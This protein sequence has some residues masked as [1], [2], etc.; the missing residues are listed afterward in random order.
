MVVLAWSS[1]A[2]RRLRRAAPDLVGAPAPRSPHHEERQWGP[3]GD[4]VVQ[5]AALD[6]AAAALVQAAGATTAPQ[7]AVASAAAL[8]DA[9][10]GAPAPP[11]LRLA[12]RAPAPDARHLAAAALLDGLLAGP[13]TAAA[14][15]SVPAPAAPVPRWVQS[16]AALLEGPGEFS[17]QSAQI[18]ATADRMAA[19]ALHGPSTE[20]AP[21]PAPTPELAAAPELAATPDPAPNPEPAPELAA[22]AIAEEP[23]EALPA[24][25]RRR[26]SLWSVIAWTPAV[27]AVLVAGALGVWVLRGG[28]VLVMSTPSMGTTAQVGSLVLTHPLGTE[29]IHR[30]MLVAF[31]APGTGAI[32]MHRVAAVLPGGRIRTRGDLNS[33]DDGWYLTRDAI[34][35]TPTLIVPWLGWIVLGAPWAFGALLLGWLLTL[36][37]PRAWRPALRYCALGLGVALAIYRLHPLVRVTIITSGKIGH[38]VAAGLV[39][40]GVLPVRVTLRAASVVI[41][42]GHL[43]TIAASLGNRGASVISAHPDVP[44]WGWIALGAVVLMPL[45]IGLASLRHERRGRPLIA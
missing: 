18:G 42:P 36:A 39:N 4:A 10:A 27:I 28:S 20:P 23:T 7:A 6:A 26:I 17:A 29:A 30:G 15:E 38:K 16:A 11:H 8:L 12:P 13:A 14:P 44:L 45:P 31:H 24:A 3:A 40:G 43:G 22:V 5:S 25:R 41:K 2:V 21:N 32:V 1:S 35:G 33:A 37:L 34:V 9:P 19:A